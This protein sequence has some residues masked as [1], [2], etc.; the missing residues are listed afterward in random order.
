MMNKKWNNKFYHG[1][2]TTP[3]LGGVG[4][5]FI[6]RDDG[7]GDGDGRQFFLIYVGIGIRLRVTR[8]F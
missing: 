5:F 7:D 4:G 1:M 2:D 8:P 3:F 6:D